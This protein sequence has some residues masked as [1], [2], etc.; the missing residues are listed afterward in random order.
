[1]G[2]QEMEIIFLGFYNGNV[3]PYLC[4]NQKGLCG[5]K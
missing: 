2:P 5:H 3:D 4:P 1:M